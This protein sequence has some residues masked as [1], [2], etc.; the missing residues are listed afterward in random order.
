M[1]TDQAQLEVLPGDGIVGRFGTVA[2][3]IHCSES[4]GAEVALLVERCRGAA[5]DESP[6][7][8]LAECLKSTDL[9]GAP[10]FEV[11]VEQRSGLFLFVRG[12]AKLTVFGPNYEITVGNRAPAALVEKQLPLPVRG[13]RSGDDPL[14]PPQQG[15][16]DLRRG[17]V[18]GGGL[19][20]C[21][22]DGTS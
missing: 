6:E 13:I 19:Q 20:L 9:F 10:P 2:F 5:A 18:P 12:Q 1:V 4:S 11:V 16:P 3:A 21:R 15:W 7:A 14:E 8:T 22:R 17:V